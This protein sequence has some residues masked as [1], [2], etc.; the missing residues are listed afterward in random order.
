MSRTIVVNSE[1]HLTKKTRPKLEKRIQ[2]KFPGDR[3]LIL[4]PEFSIQVIPSPS[5]G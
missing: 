2:E 1:I 5:D 3:I 4:D